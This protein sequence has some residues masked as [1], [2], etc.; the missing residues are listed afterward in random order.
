MGKLDASNRSQTKY[1]LFIILSNVKRYT[2]IMRYQNIPSQPANRSMLRNGIDKL[3]RGPEKW[4][5]RTTGQ[6]AEQQHAARLLATASVLG[7]TF[8]R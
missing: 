5:G 7:S 8:S 6:I 3:G 4:K 2:G 1:I